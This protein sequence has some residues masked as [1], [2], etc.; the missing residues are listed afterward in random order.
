MRVLIH[1]CYWWCQLPV[2]RIVR[3][4][5]GK[6]SQC[7]SNFLYAGRP[8]KCKQPNTLLSPF[9]YAYTW[10]VSYD[11][12]LHTSAYRP[13]GTTSHSC[14]ICTA[15]HTIC[16]WWPILSI[17]PILNSEYLMVTWPKELSLESW[18]Q[19]K[20]Y[21]LMKDSASPLFIDPRGYSAL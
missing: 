4:V 20:V 3:R 6:F 9:E 21:K 5:I 15:M 16:I 14:H 8:R 7:H 2:L 11:V 10:H 12:I 18:Y 13:R 19:S 1:A 17:C